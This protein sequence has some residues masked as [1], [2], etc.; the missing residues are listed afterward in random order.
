LKSIAG[1]VVF[2][3]GA[4][5][6]TALLMWRVRLPHSQDWHNIGLIVLRCRDRDSTLRNRKIFETAKSL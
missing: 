4:I 6:I 5:V 2:A 1:A 3:A